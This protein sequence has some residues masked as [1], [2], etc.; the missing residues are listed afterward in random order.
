MRRES[1]TRLSYSRLC[2]LGITPNG[3]IRSVTIVSGT[4]ARLTSLPERRGR[5]LHTINLGELSPASRAGT[6]FE[7]EDDERSHR[8][9]ACR[10]FSIALKEAK[11]RPVPLRTPPP[12]LEGASIAQPQK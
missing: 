12:T 2:L 10:S 6:F 9:Y 1:A 11:L 5:S 4:P 3:V 8:R 7:A